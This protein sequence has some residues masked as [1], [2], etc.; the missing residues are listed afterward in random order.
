MWHPPSFDQGDREI[1][2][3]ARAAAAGDTAAGGEACRTPSVG[4]SVPS[5]AHAVN[6]IET[7]CDTPAA[8][9]PDVPPDPP[10]AEFQPG[11]SGENL[12]LALNAI[13]DLAEHLVQARQALED[14]VAQM[15]L[16]VMDQL[17]PRLARADLAGH[18]R[19]LAAGITGGGW[20]LECPE[21]VAS[22]LSG[23]PE[24]IRLVIGPTVA[25]RRDDTARRFD[26]QV[27]ANRILEQIT[28]T[29]LTPADPPQGD[30]SE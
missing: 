1:G 27:A 18:A 13:G 8:H 9:A 15:V 29:L 21:E 5:P 25:L 17:L 10:G 26:P 20:I 19:T 4:L 11:T 23:L 30:A 16:A 3:N 22:A 24:G 28:A 12:A 14:E 6:G 2:V 7:Q